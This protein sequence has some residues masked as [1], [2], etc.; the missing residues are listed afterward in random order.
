MFYLYY[1][2]LQYIIL[3]EMYKYIETY[4]SVTYYFINRHYSKINI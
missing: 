3:T 1:I 2:L 4:I